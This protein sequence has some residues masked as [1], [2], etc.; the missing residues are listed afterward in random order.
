LLPMYTDM[1]QLDRGEFVRLALQ[2]MRDCG[3]SSGS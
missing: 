1:P 3:Y 2:A